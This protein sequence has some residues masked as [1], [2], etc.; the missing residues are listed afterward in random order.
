MSFPQRK[1]GAFS[2]WPTKESEALVYMAA[3]GSKHD[4]HGCANAIMVSG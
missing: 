2:L 3:A 1:G 4:L